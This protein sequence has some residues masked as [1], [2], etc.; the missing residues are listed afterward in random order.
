MSPAL[1][2]PGWT[3]QFRLKTQGSDMF[4]LHRVFKLNSQYTVHNNFLDQSKYSRWDFLSLSL[5]A[6]FICPFLCNQS[7]QSLGLREVSAHM[8][9]LEGSAAFSFDCGKHFET[10]ADMIFFSNVECYNGDISHVGTN[11]VH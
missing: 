6:L 11:K 8:L 7:K 5:P 1:K 4:K 2:D 10:P 9:A 3:A